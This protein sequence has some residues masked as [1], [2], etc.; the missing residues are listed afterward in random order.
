MYDYI[1]CE[2]PLDSEIQNYCFQTK[3]LYCHLENYKIDKEGQLWKLDK[4]YDDDSPGEWIPI[5]SSEA[6]RFY[7]CIGSRREDTWKWYEYYAMFKR[8]KLINIERVEVKD[9][10]SI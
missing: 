1:S 2:Y 3:S 6:I 5:N 4:N 9:D 10:F 7:T 8:G